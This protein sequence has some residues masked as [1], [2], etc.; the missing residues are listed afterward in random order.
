[1][2]ASDYQKIAV[3]TAI[4][5]KEYSVMYLSLGMCGEAGEVAEKVKKIYR[6]KQGKLS[7]DDKTALIKELGDVCWYIAN[8][9]DELGVN[10]GDVMRAN[11]KK[12]LGRMEN[13]TLHGAG[14]NR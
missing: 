3:S 2:K 5:P 10:L 6:D 14:D 11:V 7:D 13:N 4:Y 1:M 12:I 9:A 8:I